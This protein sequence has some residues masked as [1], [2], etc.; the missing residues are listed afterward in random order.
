VKS[1]RSKGEK[2]IGDGC[3][4]GHGDFVRKMVAQAT[5]R[6]ARQL[7]IDQRRTR[8]KAHIQEARRN[9][10]I[11]IEALRFGSRVEVMP[12]LRRKLAHLLVLELG[13]TRAEA[14]HRLG[15]STSGVVQILPRMN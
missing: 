6:V 12:G 8:A 9:A 15:V 4:L 3:I 2:T 13:L 1:L 11:D 7:R 5:D 10:G 14:A